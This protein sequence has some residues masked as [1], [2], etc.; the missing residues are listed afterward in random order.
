MAMAD[1]P[2]APLEK[3]KSFPARVQAFLREVRQEMRNVTWPRSED[4][5]ATTWVVLIATFVFG[6]Y[7]GGLDIALGLL[8]DW[9][10]RLV[11]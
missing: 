11:K 5:Q 8:V 1:I 4:V 6:F 3:V 10:F 7:L 9:V 2:A